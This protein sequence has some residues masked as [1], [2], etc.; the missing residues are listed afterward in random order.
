MNPTN[1]VLVEMLEIKISAIQYRMVLV[2][3]PTAYTAF[4]LPEPMRTASL[5][6]DSTQTLVTDMRNIVCNHKSPK[7]AN[8]DASLYSQDVADNSK[9]RI[10]QP[11]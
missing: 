8:K 6:A 1:L 5:S 2:R 11:D 9:I 10:E 7:N 4:F 3:T